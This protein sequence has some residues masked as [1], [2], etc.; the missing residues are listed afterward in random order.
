[1]FD[2]QNLNSSQALDLSAWT[3]LKEFDGDEFQWYLDKSKR[4]RCE[5]IQT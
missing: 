5:W 1:M 3:P 4:L 2:S